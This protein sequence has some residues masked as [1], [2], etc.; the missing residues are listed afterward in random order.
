MYKLSIL[1]LLLLI[2]I[3]SCKKDDFTI[4]EST[5]Q[6]G[7]FIINAGGYY[8]SNSEPSINFVG[9]KINIKNLFKKVNEYNL[10][11]YILDS[12]STKD[13]IYIV[14]NQSSLSSIGNV[15]VINKHSFE[16]IKTLGNINSPRCAIESNGKVY[17]SQTGGWYNGGEVSIFDANSFNFLTSVNVDYGAEKIIKVGNEIWVASNGYYSGGCTISV[18]DNSL[19]VKTHT[20]ILD[21]YYPTDMVV[22]N[23][24]DVWVSCLGIKRSGDY[25]QPYLIEIDAT[26]KVQKYKVELPSRA[27]TSLCFD[28]FNDIIYMSGG[29]WWQSSIYKLDLKRKEDVELFIEGNFNDVASN[30]GYIYVSEGFSNGKVLKYN[31]EGELIHEYR[32]GN[33]PNNIIFTE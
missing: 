33:E 6:N 12:Y 18:I 21:T 3:T 27:Y 4:D 29:K 9:N 15:E 10:E 31:Y 13:R 22:D 5:L 26:T 19:N 23:D 11:G 1:S 25:E 28:R 24:G 17:V 16:T 14:T 7:F 30:E 8:N 20:I 2:S 32:A